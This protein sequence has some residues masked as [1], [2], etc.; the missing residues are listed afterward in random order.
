MNAR[1]AKESN[2][3][4]GVRVANGV[5]MRSALPSD[6]ETLGEPEGNADSVPVSRTSLKTE[7]LWTMANRRPTASSGTRAP[8]PSRAR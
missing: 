5:D 3:V 6:H 8:L 1:F 4:D 7:E 2:G